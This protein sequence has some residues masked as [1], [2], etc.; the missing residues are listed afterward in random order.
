[1]NIFASD[2]TAA[3]LNDSGE[4]RVNLGYGTEGVGASMPIYGMGSFV[5]M[6]Y[7]PDDNGKAQAL[8]VEYGNKKIVVATRD[9]RIAKKAGALKSGDAAIVTHG[10]ARVI[11]KRATDAIFF[12]TEN[13]K[14]GGSSMVHEVS[15]ANGTVKT[16][17]GKTMIVQDKDT[18][19]LS[20]GGTSLTLDSDGVHIFGKVFACNTATATLC[21]MPGGAPPPP[22]IGSCC[23]GPAG[24]AAVGST[25][26]TVGL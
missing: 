25:R 22:G 18:I 11:V 9:N 19:T 4:V 26:V 12:Y 17:V 23:V 20:A 15:G 16:V 24:M 5:S 7:Q 10:A 13:A 8:Y 3:E 21:T 2:V 14:D 6:P 1:M